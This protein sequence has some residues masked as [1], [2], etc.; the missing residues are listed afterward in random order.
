MK[1]LGG[2]GALVVMGGLAYLAYRLLKP[3]PPSNYLEPLKGVRMRSPCGN[4]GDID[5]DGW[6]T[7][8]DIELVQKTIL[9]TFTPTDDQLARMNLRGDGSIDMGL[10]T[11]MERY[12]YGE[13]TTFPACSLGGA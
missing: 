10:T 1:K 12:L 11:L 3:K 13:D 6:I 5:G 4:L 9:G 8:A 2:V 7:T